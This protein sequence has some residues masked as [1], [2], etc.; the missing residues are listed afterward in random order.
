MLPGPKPPSKELLFFVLQGILI[1]VQMVVYNQVVH[2]RYRRILN[3]RLIFAWLFL[4]RAEHIVGRRQ[5]PRFFFF[6]FRYGSCPVP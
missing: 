6:F 5:L 4:L 2:K 1:F 3:R